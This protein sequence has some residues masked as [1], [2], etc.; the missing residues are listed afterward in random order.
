MAGDVLD[1]E[2]SSLE[3]LHPLAVLDVVLE[4]QLAV[5]LVARLGAGHVEDE[6]VRLLALLA[7]GRAIAALGRALA[8]LGGLGSAVVLRLR[9]GGL[10]LVLLVG[11][12]LLGLALGVDL[13]DLHAV[14][15]LHCL[16]RHRVGVKVEKG[17]ALALALDILVEREEG[18][19][20]LAEA[21][22]VLGELLLIPR[23]REV[24]D[25]DV[26]VCVCAFVCGGGGGV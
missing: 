7:G 14:H 17:E 11:L 3:L 8:L 15:L 9:G 24:L 1:I 6:L 4:A 18:G 16:G 10:G 22:K 19:G 23:A 12:G 5:A 20:D 26:A 25:V 21:L 2:V 13:E